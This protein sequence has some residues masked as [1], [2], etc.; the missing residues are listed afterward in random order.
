MDR[1]VVRIEGLE[2]TFDQLNVQFELDEET[3]YDKAFWFY[4][5]KWWHE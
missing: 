1:R 5:G 2:Y 3:G 4:N